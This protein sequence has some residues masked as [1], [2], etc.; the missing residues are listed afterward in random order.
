MDIFGTFV[1]IFDNFRHF[2]IFWHTLIFESFWDLIPH[3]DKVLF[4]NFSTTK[5]DMLSGQQLLRKSGEVVK[6]DEFL[7]D[8]KIIAYYFSAH[9]C[10]PCRNFTPI[11]SDFYTVKS[12]IT[13]TM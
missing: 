10:P 5:M 8:K 4:L 3:I 1:D 9:W 6:A 7:S 12:R 2:G 13:K 11:L